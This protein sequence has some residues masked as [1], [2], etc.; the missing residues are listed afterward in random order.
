MYSEL[1]I[2]FWRI[3]VTSVVFGANC[4]CQL[5]K[6]LCGV[7][8]GFLVTTLIAVYTAAAGAIRHSYSTVISLIPGHIQFNFSMLHAEKW[9]LVS[10][11]SFQN[12]LVLQYSLTIF[13]SVTLPV[14]H[15]VQDHAVRSDSCT[16][17]GQ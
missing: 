1:R 9:S 15:Y 17:F 13:N 10:I 16:S 7:L 11:S 12:M 3:V 8:I 6:V 2:V 5:D 14:S 4:C